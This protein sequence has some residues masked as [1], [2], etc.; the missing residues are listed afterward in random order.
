M[1]KFNLFL[2]IYFAFVYVIWSLL[3]DDSPTVDYLFMELNIWVFRLF[4]TIVSIFLIS[5]YFIKDKSE[6]ESDQVA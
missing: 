4:W 1:K 6:K 5:Q 3:F 2:G